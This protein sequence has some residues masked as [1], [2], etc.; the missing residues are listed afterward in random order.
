MWS[1]LSQIN[2]NTIIAII[3]GVAVYVY[4][5]IRGDK[6][7]SFSDQLRGLGK[8][9]IHALVTDPAINSQSTVDAIKAKASS[10]L[11]SAA[12]KAGIPRNS[13]TEGIATALLD[14]IVG[15]VLSE[16]RAQQTIPSQ[17]ST[18]AAQAAAIADAFK[19]PPPL[20]KGATP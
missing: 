6:S 19:N 18:I 10:L 9:V 20:I 4:H 8:Q 5:Q 15:D 1:W 17:V 11:W 3:G 14:H 7:D 2:P 13:V 12:I 16:L